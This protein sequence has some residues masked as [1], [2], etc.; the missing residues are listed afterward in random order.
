MCTFTLWNIKLS[1][2][3]AGIYSLDPEPVFIAMKLRAEKKMGNK[4]IKG[5]IYYYDQSNLEEGIHIPT[6]NER[7]SRLQIP[8]RSIWEE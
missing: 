3:K 5:R 4:D 8:E 1:F 2:R 6:S 7:L